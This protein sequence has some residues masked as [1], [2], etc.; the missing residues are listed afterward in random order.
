MFRFIMT[1][2]VRT[3]AMAMV[4]VVCALAQSAG[5]V[6]GRVTDAQGVGVPGVQLLSSP[7]GISA[8]SADDGH[9]VIRS[10]PAGNESIR[11][12][13]F[14]FRPTTVEGISVKGGGRPRRSTS[15]S[16]RQRC[17]SA[18]S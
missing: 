3:I 15:S 14:G 18:A 9:Y 1:R 6:Q 17:N 12:Y 8:I 2:A 10:V 7:S 16:T 5:R 13:R 11:A 4:P